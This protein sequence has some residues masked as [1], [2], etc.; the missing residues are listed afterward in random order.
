[1][2][3]TIKNDH[4]VDKISGIK[5]NHVSI[6]QAIKIA[7]RDCG[8]T[9]LDARGAIRTFLDN[10]DYKDTGIYMPKKMML[11]VWLENLKLAY[12]QKTR[13]ADTLANIEKHK[14]RSQA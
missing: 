14:Q 12:L 2:K 7:D 11:D 4:R 13:G 3:I 5:Y 1:M 6:D 10:L 8:F 9:M